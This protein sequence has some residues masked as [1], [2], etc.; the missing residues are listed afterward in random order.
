VPPRRRAQR[1]IERNVVVLALAGIAVVTA[2]VIAAWKFGA[3]SSQDAAFTGLAKTPGPSTLPTKAPATR[4]STTPRRRRVRLVLVASR[5][6][7]WLQVHAGSATGRPLYEG[8]LERGQTQTF[9]SR[10]LWL[11]VGAPDA[12]SVKLNGNRVAF[13]TRGPAVLLVTPRGVRPAATG[14]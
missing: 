10:R 1:R 14:A 6:N 12:L 5:G 11:N 3:P 2:L 13:P 9:V 8:T 7:C 4:P